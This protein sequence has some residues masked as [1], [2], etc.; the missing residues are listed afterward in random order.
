MPNELNE[1]MNELSDLLAPTMAKDH[2]NL[3]V[4]KEEGCYYYGLDGKT[5][6]DFTS[7]IATANTGHRHPKV[8]EAIKRAP[9]S[10]CMVLPVSL[11]M[12]RF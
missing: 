12:N 1:L 8:V 5:Y 4:V 11:C 7:G 2:P 10:S 3:P 9:T 6:L